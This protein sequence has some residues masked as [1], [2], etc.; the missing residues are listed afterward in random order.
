MKLLN[1][2]TVKV[3]VTQLVKFTRANLPTILTGLGAVS[4]GVTVYETSKGSI[5]AAKLI[6][7][8]EEEKGE[9]ISKADKAVIIAKTCWKAFLAGLIAM[10]F[11]FG[12][13][14]IS[15]KRQAVLSAAYALTTN[16][17]REYQEKVR[18]TIGE[19]KEEKIKDDIAADKVAAYHFTEATPISGTGP[20][21]IFAWS[22][23][24]FRGNLED[25]RQTINDLNDD[26]YHSKGKAY[27]SGEIALNDVIYAISSACHAP[28]L[29]SVALGDVFGFR[30]DLTGP[31]DLDIRYGKATNG[32]PCGYINVKPLPLVENLNENVYY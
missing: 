19:K 2:E 5:K 15:L 32:E 13:N 9:D 23:T 20:L 4:F 28:Q 27:F 17:F 29:G 3:G 14:R 6:E 12:A 11:F 7:K 8:A 22:N 18:E 25:I 26:L 1:A 30:A 24:P 10:G 31:I 16:E 21:W